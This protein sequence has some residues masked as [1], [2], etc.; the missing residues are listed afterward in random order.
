MEEKNELTVVSVRLVK[1]RSLYSEKPILN[2]EDV[3]ELVAKELSTYDREVMCV[4]NMQAD[5]K[6]TRLNSSH[7]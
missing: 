3:W 1:E 6:S 4:L 5:R 7:P 2:K